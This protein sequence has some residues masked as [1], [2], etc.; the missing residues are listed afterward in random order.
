[1]K[2]TV[3][4]SSAATRLRRGLVFIVLLLLGFL[5]FARARSGL[6][7]SELLGMLYRG[8]FDPEL[9]VAVATSLLRCVIGGSIGVAAGFVLGVLIGSMRNVSLA[10]LPTF[11]VLKL[12]SPFA[13]IPLILTWFGLGEG[14]KIAFIALVAYLPVLFN[15]VDGVI[16]APWKLVEVGKVNVFSR[17]QV[18]RWAVL[19]S[20]M[21]SIFNGLYLALIASWMATIGAEYM[22]TSGG[23]IGS[24][25]IGARDLMQ[26]DRLVAGVVVIGTVGYLMQAAGQVAEKHVLRWRPGN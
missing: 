16:S 8:L 1:M 25:L 21:P 7:A 12:I 26:F 13:W 19:P 11:N 10:L 2:G 24:Y 4:T 17:L 18:L 6:P 5:L 15:T 20:A 14:S 3:E 22:L 9:W 23:G